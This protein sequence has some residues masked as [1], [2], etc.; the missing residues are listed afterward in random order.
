M[1]VLYL[2]LVYEMQF[3]NSIM[4]ILYNINMLESIYKKIHFAHDLKQ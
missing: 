4:L 3:S 2:F 1:F